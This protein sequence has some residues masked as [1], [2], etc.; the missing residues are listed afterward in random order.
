MSDLKKKKANRRLGVLFWELT[1]CASPF[2]FENTGDST[3]QFEILKGVREK[4]ISTT[5]ATFVKIYQKS[6][7]IDELES[8]DEF[9]DCD[10]T[11]KKFK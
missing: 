11:L 10:V 6:K 9:S 4:P 7:L 5:N 1:S 8:E 2:N 3:I